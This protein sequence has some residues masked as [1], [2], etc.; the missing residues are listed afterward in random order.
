MF[1]LVWTFS[2]NFI[3]YI[4]VFNLVYL[5]FFLSIFQ[6][7]TFWK[8]WFSFYSLFYVVFTMIKTCLIDKIVFKKF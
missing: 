6:A 5:F 7:C 1:A 8:C 2:I 4:F 3:L